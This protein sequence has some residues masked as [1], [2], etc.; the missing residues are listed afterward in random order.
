MSEDKRAKVLIVDDVPA[1]LMLLR[2]ELEPEGY[3]I[4]VATNGKT[5]LKIAASDLPDIIL[6]DIDGYS[7]CCKLKENEATKRIPVIFITV[8]DDKESLIKGFRVGGVDYITKPFEKEEVILR[9]KTHLEINQLNKILSEKN[10]D[11]EQRTEELSLANQQLQQANQRLKEEIDR[12]KQAEEAKE[13][14]ENQLSM[15]SQ[16]EAQ[17]W[18]I[19]GFIGKSKTI[20]KILDDVRKLQNAE[21]TNVLITGESGTGKELITRAIHF[22]S[23]RAKKPFIPVNCSTI[24][25]ELAE[26]LLFGHVRGAFTGANTSHKGYFELASGGTLFLDEIGDMPLQLQPKLLRVMEDGCV[27]PVGSTHEK[28]VDVRII[29]TTNQNLESKIVQGTFREDLYFRLA[30]FTVTIPPLRERKEDI[31]LLTEHFLKMFAQEMGRDNP[32]L[33]PEAKEA[34]EAYHFPGNVRELKNIIENALIK[35]GNSEIHPEYLHFIN[36]NG[37]SAFHS[38]D[39]PIWARRNGRPTHPQQ[40]GGPIAKSVQSGSIES[41]GMNQQT[42]SSQMIDEEKILAY[43]REHGSISNEECRQL[44]STD[45]HHASYLLKKMN[46]NGLLTR[47]SERRWS[48]YCLP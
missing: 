7:V 39:S 6:L 47:E 19:D 13:Q 42:A 29:A 20:A 17:R 5:G 9:V 16:Q 22:G 30:G 28:H 24:P 14:A 45:Y 36:F 21:T 11:L 27:M 33:S 34:L 41:R 1:N 23:D 10:R 31:P 2:E 18:G 43:V 4:I 48:R 32:V 38:E 37:F 8:K 25:G 35:S 46:R 12:R 26:T 3:K 15:I 40:F 44:L